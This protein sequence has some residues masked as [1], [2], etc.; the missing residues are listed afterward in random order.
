MQE[1]NFDF[2]ECTTGNS[3]LRAVDHKTLQ[4]EWS[5]LL[6]DDMD[7]NGKGSSHLK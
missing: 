2:T 5:I 7:S 6:E 4:E 3:Q 1:V